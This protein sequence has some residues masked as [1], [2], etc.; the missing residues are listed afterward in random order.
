[1]W[2][3]SSDRGDG[4]KLVCNGPGRF[5]GFLELY[6]GREKETIQQDQASRQASDR[7]NDLQQTLQ[8]KQGFKRK[9][10]RHTNM[11][12]IGAGGKGGREAYPI[13]AK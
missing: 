8:T 3:L 6:V 13:I 10:R 4:Q 9:A 2:H 1:M 11:V 7:F 5:C 12:M